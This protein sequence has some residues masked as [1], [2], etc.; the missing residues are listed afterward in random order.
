MKI[1]VLAELIFFRLLMGILQ[2]CNGND[3]IRMDLLL[4]LQ[5]DEYVKLHALIQSDD[6]FPVI[7]TSKRVG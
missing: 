5:I 1:L 2:V 6:F 4:F 7:S 3:T